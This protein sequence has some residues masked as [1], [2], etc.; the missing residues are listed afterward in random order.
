MA[1]ERPTNPAELRETI[2]NLASIMRINVT[3]AEKT[4]IDDMVTEF[5]NEY[6][7]F[8]YRFNTRPTV[9]TLRRFGQVLDDVQYS[10]FVSKATLQTKIDDFFAGVPSHRY[11]W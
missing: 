3:T 11:N 8:T 2:K 10:D 5:L 1:I 4:L 7:E 9:R 6:P